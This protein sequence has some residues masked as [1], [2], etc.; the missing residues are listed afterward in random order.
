MLKNDV[1]IIIMYP[2]LISK[3]KYKKLKLIIDERG[4]PRQ[5]I[6]TGDLFRR[7]IACPL[8][9]N[10]MSLRANK[11]TKTKQNLYSYSCMDCQ[12]KRKVTVSISESLIEQI[13]RESWRGR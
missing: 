8:C 1:T 6:F 9:D 4:N 5:E 11:S 2:T 7:K 3:K 13:G 12:R 10:I